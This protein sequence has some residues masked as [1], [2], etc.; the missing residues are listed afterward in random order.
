MIEMAHIQHMTADQAVG[1]MRTFSIM[2]NLVNSA[3]VTHR[4]R[5][6]QQYDLFIEQQ[7]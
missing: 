7:Q 1:V 3:E 6:T 5:M 2:L 4:T